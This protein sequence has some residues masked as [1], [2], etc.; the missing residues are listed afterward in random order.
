MSLPITDEVQHASYI[1]SMNA[2]LDFCYAKDAYGKIGTVA[3]SKCYG[4][5]VDHPSQRQHDCIMLEPEQKLDNNFEEIILAIDEER[6]LR[7]WE[8][9]VTAM[10]IPLAIVDLYKLKVFCED[11]RETTYKSE[12]WASKMYTTLH[13]LIELERRFIEDKLQVNEIDTTSSEAV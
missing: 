6:V 12:V 4:C 11:W 9:Q 13:R 3:D 5:K 7:K 1:S 2:V 8:R 10:D